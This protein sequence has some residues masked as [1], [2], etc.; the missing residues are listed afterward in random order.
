[1]RTKTINQL[2]NNL[3]KNFDQREA[4]ILLAKI[5][6]KDRVYILMHPEKTV[7]IFKQWQL[8]R[9]ISRRLHQTPLAYLLGHKEFFGLDFLVTKNVLIPRPETEL[10]VEK[11]LEKTNT[12]LK[13]PITL[14]DVGTGSG[15]IPISLAKNS[16]LNLE[17]LALDISAKALKVA[18]KNSQTHQTNITFIK[19]NLL[20]SLPTKVWNNHNLI[21]TANLP[22]LSQTEFTTEASIQAEPKL[23]LV[24][25]QEGNALMKKLLEQI[26]AKIKPGH[27][28]ELFLEMNP[29]QIT[30]IKNYAKQLFVCEAVIIPDLAGLNRVLYLSL[31]PKN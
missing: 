26:Q 23:A 8:G 29:N 31:S 25:E 6:D 22:Y 27:R 1:M 15:C 9:M 3:P 11:V 16:S 4:E 18:Q 28:V 21:I 14:I 5:L 19:S 12:I 2:L 30:E 7:S 24:A 17:I 13:K 20:T 10:L